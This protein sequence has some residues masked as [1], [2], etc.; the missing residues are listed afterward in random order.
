MTPWRTQCLDTGRPGSLGF[1]A[2][3]AMT[4]WRTGSR[5]WRWLQNSSLQ[6]GHGDDAVEN[7]TELRQDSGAGQCFNAATAMTPWR[8]WWQCRFCGFCSS[9]QC[10]HGDDAVENH[11]VNCVNAADKIASMRPRR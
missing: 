11:N 7:T 6:C 3:T 10:G 4:P 5:D 8:T 2:A 9:L 1:N